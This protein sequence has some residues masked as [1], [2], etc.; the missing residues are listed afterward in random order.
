M[1]IANKVRTHYD[2]LKVARNAPIEVI[3][4]A[5]RTLSQKYPPDRNNG[6]SEAVRIMT[7]INASY[8]VLSDRDK[9]RKHDMW[10]TEQELLSAQFDKTSHKGNRDSNATNTQQS[11]Y[12][13]YPG[14]SPISEPANENKRYLSLLGDMLRHVLRHWILWAVMGALMLGLFWVATRDSDSE[15]IVTVATNS[16]VPN[17]SVIQVQPQPLPSF[18]TASRHALEEEAKSTIINYAFAVSNG[19]KAAALSFLEESNSTSVQ[20]A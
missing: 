16:P 15:K 20:A 13:R 18:S 17:Q 4:A 10:I 7:I 5:Y 2:N 1:L 8:E 11:T 9:R 14:T 3:R 6:D 19:N 12:S